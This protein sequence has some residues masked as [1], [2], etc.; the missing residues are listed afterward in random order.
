MGYHI[1]L[2]KPRIE[3]LLSFKNGKQSPRNGQEH[4][5]DLR[6][7][8]LIAVEGKASISPSMPTFNVEA[9]LDLIVVAIQNQW[10]SPE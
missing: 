6:G 4:V 3:C 5:L 8:G 7:V 1:T 2:I 10:L 9:L